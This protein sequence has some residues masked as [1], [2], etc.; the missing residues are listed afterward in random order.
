[1]R[2]SLLSFLAILSMTFLNA[3]TTLLFEDFESGPG[4]FSL[5]TGA[6]GGAT[7][8]SGDNEW[9]V[10]DVY[11]GGN[12][13]VAFC[14]LVLGSPFTIDPTPSQPVGISSTDGNYMHIVSD[15]AANSGILNSNYAVADGIACIFSASHFSSMTS[16]VS[17]SAM[18]NVTLDFWWLCAGDP[19]AVGEVYYS[20][21][22][23]LTW[24]QITSPMA[25]YQGQATW[26]QQSITDPA[27]DNQSTLRFGF[28]FS[29]TTASAAADPAFGIDDIEITADAVAC[30]NSFSSFSQT[31]CFSYTV[32]SGD[33][34]YTV[35]GTSTVMD[36][37]TNVSGCDSIMTITL[38]IDTVNTTVSDNSMGVLT[39]N[40]TTGTY[41]WLSS[42]DGIPQVLVGE[43]NQSFNFL[44]LGNGY[45]SVVVTEGSCTDT[46]D[47]ILTDV[48][49]LKEFE[50]TS[51]EVYPN[52]T[53][54]EFNIIL[55]S[56]E[57]MVLMTISDINGK[58]IRT[59]WFYNVNEINGI[60]FEAESGVYIITLINSEGKLSRTKL[61]K[62]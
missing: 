6:L 18:N 24:T 49:S 2:K 33:E 29:N 51:F 57:S 27:W 21:D 20:L 40:S 36:T 43:T 47:C 17:T 15:E 26:V 39:A 31:T 10:N 45:F 61:I 32:P 19:A 1:M 8:S 50:Q 3:Q 48:F 12:G 44:S 11:A 22:M 56:Y 46:S 55:S 60:D 42:C 54:Q 4:S 9:I 58:I 28:R 16:D 52:P 35:G 59:E 23:G 7:G 41:Q 14:A 53:L 25:D 62:E 38:T 30:S 34:T 13:T 5:N 37:I